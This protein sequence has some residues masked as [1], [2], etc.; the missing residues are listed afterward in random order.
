MAMSECGRG[1]KY[2]PPN[3]NDEKPC[4]FCDTSEPSLDHYEK[5]SRGRPPKKD[6]MDQSY[7]L[8]LSQKQREELR[9]LAKKNHK[10]EASMLRELIKEAFER[11]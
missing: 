5:R 7:R 1:C 2:W 6:A 4:R 8:R 10:S 9:K 3:D 11:S